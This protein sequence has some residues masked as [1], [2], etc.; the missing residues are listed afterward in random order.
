MARPGDDFAVQQYTASV[1]SNHAR[2]V[3][4]MRDK[5][6]GARLIP[7]QDDGLGRYDFEGPSA[8][9]GGDDMTF[10][11]LIDVVN[12]LQHI[13][14][15]SAI[16]REMTGDE[17]SAPARMAGGALFFGPIG[18]AA[19][20]ANVLAEVVTGKDIGEHIAAL[21]GS[22]DDIEIAETD[23]GAL[24][25]TVLPGGLSIDEWLKTPPP[26][27]PEADTPTVDGTPTAIPPVRE[28]ESRSVPDILNPTTAAAAPAG[29]NTAPVD[30]VSVSGPVAIESLPADIL[31]AL[32][33]DGSVQPV[34]AAS[35]EA[36]KAIERD[37]RQDEASA[38]SPFG[39]LGIPG[40]E[41]GGLSGLQPAL[42]PNPAAFNDAEA[43]G[44]VA[45]DGGWFT[46][47][48]NDALVR[49]EDSAAL[50]REAQK[51]FVDVS[52]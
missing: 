30:A 14:G 16:Y 42:A 13:P 47:A 20:T 48:M 31:A 8:T 25:D 43:F 39:S 23:A 5:G 36:A 44:A 18:L 34:V 3:A 35:A 41:D 19:A 33:G 40:E 10:A 28:I 27:M 49:Y 1:P 24:S 11:D 37:E 29:G 21:F 17:L 50:R 9:G 52:R 7:G 45:S 12:P 15:V 26:G 4:V 32:Y 51:V 22:E 46:Q 2:N 6:E 38:A